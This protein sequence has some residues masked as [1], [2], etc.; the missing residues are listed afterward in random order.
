M[1]DVVEVETVAALAAAEE[2][3]A[4][5]IW[6]ACSSTLAKTRISVLATS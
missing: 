6:P 5:R 3:E 1:A 2:T 4:V